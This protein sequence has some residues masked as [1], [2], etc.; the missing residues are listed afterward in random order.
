MAGVSGGIVNLIE[1][2]LIFLDAQHSMTNGYRG[3]NVQCFYKS[4]LE[5]FLVSILS[6]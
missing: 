2:Y 1:N 3:L 5:L 4:Y 6:C